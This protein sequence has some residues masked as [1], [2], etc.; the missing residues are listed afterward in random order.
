[1]NHFLVKCIEYLTWIGKQLL[2]YE[3]ITKSEYAENLVS[4]GVVPINSSD[5]VMVVLFELMIA[6]ILSM[7]QLWL[8]KYHYTLLPR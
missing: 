2:K 7:E 8:V 3:T 6:S 1:M 4:L 5:F